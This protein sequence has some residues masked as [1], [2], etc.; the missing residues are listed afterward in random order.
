[1]DIEK[2]FLEVDAQKQINR[3]AKKYNGKKIVIYGAGEYFQILVK[4]YDLSKL[5]IVAICD[6]KFEKDKNAESYGF[7]AIV[8]D[9]LKTLDY[10]LI[11]VALLRDIYL[12]SYI[13]TYILLDSK[14]EE[15]PVIPMIEPT[16]WYV[17]KTLLK[18]E[19]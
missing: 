4:N 17:I 16:F 6:K 7:T 15:K 5:N 13:E 1:M 19:K 18:N 9:D 12:C 14:N 3:L 10:D 11:L 8:P 2:Y